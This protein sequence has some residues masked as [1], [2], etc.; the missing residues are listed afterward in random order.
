MSHRLDKFSAFRQGL[1]I[2]VYLA[3]LTALEYFVAVTFKAVSI[4]VVVAVIKVALV[5]YY[6]M[7]IYKLNE[8]SDAEPHSY[9]FKTGTNRLGLWLF[10]LSDSFVF[11]GLLTAR[12]N[13]LGLTRPHL[14]QILGLAVTAVLLS[15]SFFM[16]RGETAMVHGDK[17]GFIRNTIITFVLGLGFLLGVVAVEWPLA[18][19][20]GLTAG[21][22]A[23]GAVFYMMTGMHAFHVFTG[24]ILLLVVLY[25][26]R[27][28]K[29]SAEK[30]WGVEA[31][32]VYWHFVDLVWIIFYPALYLIGT[33]L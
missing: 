19:E 31:A 25:K 11:A 26:T 13:L 15:S 33:A 4:L 6:Y 5:M 2:F 28:D 14:N 10:L 22:G 1:V 7:H 12:V 3:V 30:H 23:A 32:A 16:N 24:L 29:Y 8:E 20:E 9:S 21:S 27:K 17:K 18:A